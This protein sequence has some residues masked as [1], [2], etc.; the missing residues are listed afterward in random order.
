MEKGRIGEIYNI[1]GECE[2]TNLEVVKAILN[3]LE[4]DVNSIGFIKDRP[5][6]DRRYAMDISKIKSEINW[7]PQIKFE[8]G[9]AG[10]IQWYL[11]NEKWRNDIITGDYL[12]Y[13][14]KQYGLKIHHK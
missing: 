11:D 6:H 3:I 12:E 1:G 14:H 9:L 8:E 4:K 10:T 5:G 2:K 7:A 13:Y